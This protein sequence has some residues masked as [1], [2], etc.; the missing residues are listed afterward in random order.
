MRAIQNILFI[1]IL[2]FRLLLFSALP[3]TIRQDSSYIHYLSLGDESNYAI[4]GVVPFI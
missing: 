2:V 4:M 1:F 3:Y